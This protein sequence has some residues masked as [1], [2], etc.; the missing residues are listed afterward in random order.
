MRRILKRRIPEVPEI[1]EIEI[2][3]KYAKLRLYEIKRN[4]IKSHNWSGDDIIY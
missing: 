1:N 4:I 3:L 2:K